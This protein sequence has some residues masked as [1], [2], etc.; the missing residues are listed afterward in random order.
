[1]NN[2]LKNKILKTRNTLKSQKKSLVVHVLTKKENSM[3]WFVSQKLKSF[4]FV[5]QQKTTLSKNKN[6][7]KTQWT[8]KLPK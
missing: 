2:N 3:S 8:E 1:M 7:F 6:N 4:K 5:N